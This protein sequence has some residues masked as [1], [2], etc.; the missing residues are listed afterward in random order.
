[1][2]DPIFNSDDN[3]LLESPKAFGGRRI[4]QELNKTSFALQK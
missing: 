3:V 1:M 2:D 4:L